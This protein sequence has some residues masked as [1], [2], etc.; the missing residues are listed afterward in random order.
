[1][2]WPTAEKH[3]PQINKGIEEIVRDAEK[4]VQGM[5]R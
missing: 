2:L 5:M 3:A 1:V 4:K